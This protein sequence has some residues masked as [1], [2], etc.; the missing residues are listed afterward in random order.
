MPLTNVKLL[1]GFD[2]TDTPSGAEGRWI[3]GDFVRFRY[4]QPEKIGGFA[5][6]GQQTISG[7]ARAQHTWT[8]LEGRKYGAIGTS[9]VLL[10][11]Y[12]DAFYDITPLDTAI[13]GATFTST[14]GQATVT[15]NKVGHGLVASEYF[16][17]TSV[18]LPGG[19]ATGYAT[20]DFT[21]NTFEII[22]A[23][24]D[25]FTITMPSVE[26]GTG[27]STAGSATINPYIEIGSVIQTY[28]YGWGTGTWGGNVSGAQTTTLNGALLNDAN[29]TGGSGT[30]IT[31]T[32]ATGFSGTGGTI[33]VDQELITY[34]GVSSNDLTGISRGALGTSTAAHSNGATVTEVSSFIAWGQQ[35]TTSSVILDPGNWTLDNFGEVLTCTIRNG[36]TFTWDPGVSNPLNNR[37]V[38]MASAPTKSI[39]T[40]VSDRDRHFIHFG[41]E[42]IVGQTGSQ[43]P[44]FIRFS[45]QENFNVYTPTA[46][47]TAGTFRLDTGNTIVTAVNGKDYVLILTDQAAYTMQFVGP[48]FTFSIRQVGTNCGCMGPHAAVYSD[49][50][51]FWMGN[52]GG[53]FVFDGTVKL[54]PSLVEDFVFTTDGDNLGINYASN[55]IVFGAHNSLYNE[56]IWFYPQGTPTTGPSQQIDRSVVYNYVENTWSTMSLSRT[57]YADSVTYANPYATEYDSTAVPQFPVVNGVTNTFGATTYFAHETGVNKITLAGTEESIN[58]FV[59][60][61]DFDLPV[62]GDGQFLLNIRRFLP[63]F[64]NLSGNVSITMGTK[65]FPI[66]G[67]STTVSFVVNSTTSKI[68]TRI[69]GRLANIKIE[70]TAVNDNWRFGT[71][72]ADVSQD[73]MR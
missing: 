56:I 54:L 65:D 41:T 44:M 28:G 58:A 45:D 35:T 12:E 68:D 49:G 48:P 17:F 18:T 24:A 3:D 70:N 32:S 11:Y 9:K 71:F 42:T 4:N 51:V 33:L 67:N 8:D 60:S 38:V 39:S 34:T 15:V 30:S 1:P 22:T 25:T 6:I 73:G 46:T 29:G 13:T 2:K 72:R 43:D 63:D 66:A 53:F 37:A 20:T 21:T 7:P 61:G 26:S 36:K 62:D 64:K 59:Q 52:S 5:A 69:R 27:M 10:V 57:T 31:L 47:N 40:L 55:Q 19:G 16:T 14:N 50:K 23:T